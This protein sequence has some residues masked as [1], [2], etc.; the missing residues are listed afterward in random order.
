MEEGKHK[1]RGNLFFFPSLDFFSSVPSSFFSVME[2]AI[3][4]REDW[5]RIDSEEIN[6]H[7]VD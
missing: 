6:H 1:L 2:R 3:G 4:E 7:K 5:E